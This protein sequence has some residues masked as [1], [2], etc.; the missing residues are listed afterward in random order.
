MVTGRSSIS[1]LDKCKIK[2]EK[3][4]K[5]MIDLFLRIKSKLT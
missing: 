3:E 1:H 5:E 4:A 2:K